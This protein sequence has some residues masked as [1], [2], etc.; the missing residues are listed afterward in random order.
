MV[1]VALSSGCATTVSRSALTPA[2]ARPIRTAVPEGDY[3]FGGSIAV[4]DVET[5]DP[6]E[7]GDPG[8]WVP[9]VAGS[10]HLR[11]HVILGL[12]VGAHARFARLEHATPTIAGHHRPDG[13][14]SFSAGPEVAY[15]HRFEGSVVGVA[16]GFSASLVRV[17]WAELHEAVDGEWTARDTGNDVGVLFHVAG[18]VQ[19]H[20]AEG[21]LLELGGA[22]Q[23]HIRN[24]AFSDDRLG[25]LDDDGDISSDAYGVVPY[26]TLRYVTPAGIYAAGQVLMPM[27]FGSV[28]VQRFGGTVTLGVEIGRPDA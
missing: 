18:A 15:A 27:G 12:S 11:H 14:V 8:L 23:N 24:V 4:S 6:P 10:F 3:E 25:T 22:V 2:V 5:H 21:L 9:S 19:L 26:G 17:P 1:A 20:L 13:Q 28:D 16:G 7:Q